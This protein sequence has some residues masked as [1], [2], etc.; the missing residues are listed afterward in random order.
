MTGKIRITIHDHAPDP[1][2]IKGI[3]EQHF[4]EEQTSYEES[5]FSLCSFLFEH[6]DDADIWDDEDDDADG[7][8][9]DD[10]YYPDGLSSD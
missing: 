3:Y 2:P 10:G 9:D 8:P 1:A 5:L 6:M 4:N 7:T